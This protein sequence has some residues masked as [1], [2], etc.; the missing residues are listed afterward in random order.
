MIRCCLLFSCCVV[1]S[2]VATNDCVDD[3]FQS[4]YLIQSGCSRV[5]I[6]SG[7]SQAITVD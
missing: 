3:S 6:H 4:R 1:M 5:S 2:A 7:N